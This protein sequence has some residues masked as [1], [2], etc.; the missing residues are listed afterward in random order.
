MSTWVER[1]I[2][3][4][5]AMMNSKIPKYLYEK[6]VAELEGHCDQ[7]LGYVTKVHKNIKILS[8]TVSS[9]GVGVFFKV[10]VKIDSILPTKNQKY[11]GIVYLVVEKGIFIKAKGKIDV[12]VS[13]RVMT[14]W[15]YNEFKKCFES[16]TEGHKYN[17]IGKDS[18]VSVILT[19]IEYENQKF[20]CFG[21]LC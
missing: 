18:K 16:I 8:N 13:S 6:C 7:N 4:N 9:A 15:K 5:P 3:L 19:K 12:M 17:T 2:L 10:K 21:K 20:S 1:N 11:S 14:D